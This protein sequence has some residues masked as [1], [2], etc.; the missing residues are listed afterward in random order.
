[1]QPIERAFLDSIIA[2]PDDDAPRLV[3]ADWLEDFG[4]PGRGEFIRVQVELARIP[5]CRH[6]PECLRLWPEPY[7]GPGHGPQCPDCKRRAT[8]LRREAGLLD[9]LPRLGMQAAWRR[10][11][12]CDAFPTLAEWLSHGQAVARSNP[13]EHVG[14]D[15][16]PITLVPVNSTQP[17]MGLRRLSVD[18]MQVPPGAEEGEVRLLLRCVAQQFDYFAAEQ[19]HAWQLGRDGRPV[20]GDQADRVNEA[21]WRK[22]LPAGL[23]AWAR[24]PR[25]GDLVT[26]GGRIV[27]I[28][29]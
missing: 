15:G 13:V 20:D 28:A 18:P 7:A 6:R 10:G 21:A 2:A 29:L 23:V 17:G 9:C 26:G 22:A 4:R 3:Y 11:F 27:G 19:A 24:L 5:G 16:S 14:L 12:V 8:L 1:M 25:G